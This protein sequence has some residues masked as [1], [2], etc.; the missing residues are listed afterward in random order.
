M[1]HGSCNVGEVVGNGEGEI[2]NL[3]YARALETQLG[4]VV[5][6]GRIA[7][8]EQHEALEGLWFGSEG[9]AGVKRDGTM[10][11]VRGRLMVVQAVMEAK[12]ER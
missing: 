6:E 9:W 8:G 2:I 11:V 1:S 10:K 3:L 4:Y 7:A 5:K 12:G